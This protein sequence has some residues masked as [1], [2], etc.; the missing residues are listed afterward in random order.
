MKI[1]V[2][3]DL[4][5]DELVKSLIA[6]SH[7]HGLDHDLHMELS[8]SKKPDNENPERWAKEAEHLLVGSLWGAI[9]EACA[10]V[11][12]DLPGVSTKPDWNDNHL[13][14]MVSD[15]ISD[16]ISAYFGVL[17]PNERKRWDDIGVMLPSVVMGASFANLMYGGWL[18][19]KGMV[20]DRTS[21]EKLQL[22]I[23]KTVWNQGAKLA[24]R[25]S[26]QHTATYVRWFSERVG[27]KADQQ[28]HQW[29]TQ[30]VGKM[31][32][33]F[34]EGKLK[35]TDNEGQTLEHH[36][37]IQTWQQL[38]T[39]LYHHFKSTPE[40]EHD[41]YRIA[42]TESRLAVNGGKLLGMQAMGIK[43]VYYHVQANA[44]VGCKKMYLND[45]GTPKVFKLDTILEHFWTNGGLNIGRKQSLMGEEGG[46]LPVGG[47]VHP[48]CRCRP[49]IHRRKRSETE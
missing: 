8:K 36:A 10:V 48:L 32:S 49:F 6:V 26:A 19:S 20:D 35:P 4:E 7:T 5:G 25:W 13:L 3:T 34:V 2:T 21:L 37:P 43:E 29:Q 18:S 1:R 31:V 45:D 44:C 22:E 42:A 11:E 27:E 9:R 41:W 39:E 40:V 15:L 47:P 12:R 23:A 24:A 17:L 16:A 33:Q 28:L 46:W 38:K 14:H 30:A